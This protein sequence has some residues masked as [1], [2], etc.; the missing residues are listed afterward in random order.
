[1]GFVAFVVGQ[2]TDEH[3]KT[4]FL[5]LLAE[6]I[7][8]EKKRVAY[9]INFN[10]K[11]TSLKA[12]VVRNSVTQTH[13]HTQTHTHTCKHTRTHARTHACTHGQLFELYSLISLVFEVGGNWV[14]T[15][16]VRDRSD[17]DIFRKILGNQ[18]SFQS[19]QISKNYRRNSG[20][21]LR[22]KINPIDF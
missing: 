14:V 6:D 22:Q 1:M 12:T 3:L 18:V 8:R 15:F 10:N 2:S 4:N 19:T 5:K 11:P 21:T 17:R 20:G 13:I 9:H 7:A 16:A